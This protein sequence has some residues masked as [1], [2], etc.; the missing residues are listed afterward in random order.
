MEL[1]NPGNLQNLFRVVGLDERDGFVVWGATT[2]RPG[3][4]GKRGRQRENFSRCREREGDFRH[5]T[6]N[7][8]K[9]NLVPGS[10]NLVLDQHE[11][12]LEIGRQRSASPLDVRG[13]IGRSRTDRSRKTHG[14]GTVPCA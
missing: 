2:I 12:E 1:L 10:G 6:R 7:E 9:S 3:L 5:L 8:P 4:T 11:S 14:D 13:E